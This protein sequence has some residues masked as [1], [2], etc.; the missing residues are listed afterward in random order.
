MWNVEAVENMENMFKGAALFNCFE[1]PVPVILP[2]TGNIQKW[3]VSGNTNVTAM[4]ANAAAMNAAYDDD[5]PDN[6][7]GVTP[8]IDTFFDK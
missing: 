7:Y 5:E 6:G 4:F 8:T 3:K 2:N 1:D